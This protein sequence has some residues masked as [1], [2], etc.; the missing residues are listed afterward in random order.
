[1]S[2][3]ARTPASTIRH[4]D[5]PVPPPGR[6]FRIQSPALPGLDAPGSDAGRPRVRASGLDMA[7]SHHRGALVIGPLDLPVLPEAVERIIRLAHVGP[8]ARV[9]LIPSAT[10]RRWAFAPDAAARAVTEAP[11]L[12]PGE[13]P[14]RLFDE[15]TALPER[16][17]R[18]VIAGDHLALD[19][20]HGLGDVTLLHL[21]VNVL[22]GAIDPD[23]LP[24]PH[25]I[26]PLLVAS[27]AVAV[28]PRRLVALA[29]FHRD[30]PRAP[31]S[32][33]AV[34]RELS[35]RHPASA[36][37]R[38]PAHRV[39]AVRT[40]RTE[41]IPGTGIFSVYTVALVR[42]LTAAGVYLDPMVTLPFDARGA[43]PRGWTTHANFA[44]GLAFP[45]DIQTRPA[46]LQRDMTASGRMG[47]PTA[48]LALASLKMRSRSRVRRA[49]QAALTVPAHGPIR[50]ELLHSS[51]GHLPGRTRGW[52]WAGSGQP[53][54]IGTGVPP[55]AA[56]ITVTT[57]FVE[58]AITMTAAF[59][60]DVFD[61]TLIRSALD[62]VQ[63]HA[64]DLVGAS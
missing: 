18:I 21:I 34:R 31:V 41:S 35:P 58:G 64:A 44:A 60:D 57:A 59:R 6:P 33:P 55:S 47:R 23:D 45:I 30:R 19:F 17:L 7:H 28:D 12:S 13:A 40:A 54:V 14:T 50:A 16:P 49:M 46:D 5:S 15:L 36:S 27:A 51:V 39:D 53:T 37:V 26:P 20:D 8:H 4:V 29:R 1:M 3:T 22:V 24:S 11:P 32:P 63:R 38:I 2:R 56:G 25:A 43:L 42:G 52:Q 62:S 48:N 10:E 61:P 9:G